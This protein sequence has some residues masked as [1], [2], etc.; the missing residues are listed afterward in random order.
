[1]RKEKGALFLFLS[2]PLTFPPISDG[3]I[4]GTPRRINPPERQRPRVD[5]PCNA[6]PTRRRI[7]P[8]GHE[9]RPVR[10]K[11]FFA[12][13]RLG[14]RRDPARI[15]VAMAGTVGVTAVGMFGNGAGWGL[16]PVEHTLSLIVG[17][18]TR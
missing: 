2:L 5:R 16:A 17:G 12:L 6:R 4:G 8:D 18:I 10:G 3:T 15:W 14:K 13:V 7:V 11:A 9:G 1:M